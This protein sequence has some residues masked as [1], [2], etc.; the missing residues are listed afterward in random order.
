MTEIGDRNYLSG[1][2]NRYMKD[3][4]DE[5]EQE[6][7]NQLE[8]ITFQ[9]DI[10]DNSKLRILLRNRLDRLGEPR[11]IDWTVQLVN[12]E[13]LRSKLDDALSSY[14]DNNDDSLLIK[15]LLLLKGLK[16]NDDKLNNN[17]RFSII[18]TKSEYNDDGL[19]S[20]LSIIDKNKGEKIEIFIEDAN[21]GR[22]VDMFDQC[23][24][25]TIK[26]KCKNMLYRMDYPNKVTGVT[27]P[28][29]ISL[30]LD[31][32]G[33]F[34]VILNLKNKTSLHYSNR[35]RCK[36]G[37]NKSVTDPTKLEELSSD[38]KEYCGQMPHWF[39]ERVKILEEK[40]KV[41]TSYP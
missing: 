8:K 5:M 38:W 29:D 16:M 36:D 30:K 26:T 32:R 7:Y 11:T 40:F 20:T 24:Y 41:L 31:G 10:I 9:S 25:I 17:R 14:I 28:D 6:V 3:E 15:E 23:Y 12:L 19:I 21:M 4:L 1:Y 13:I 18:T 33:A 34:N 27:G 22:L 39:N 37:F 2:M 35:A